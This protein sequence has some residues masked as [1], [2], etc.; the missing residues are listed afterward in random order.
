MQHAVI[1]VGYN[2]DAGYWIMQNSWGEGWGDG[3]FMKLKMRD[4]SWMGGLGECLMY[5]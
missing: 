5:K 3:G 4:S 1:L 2:L